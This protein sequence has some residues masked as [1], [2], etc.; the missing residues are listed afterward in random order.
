MFIVMTWFYVGIGA[1]VLTVETTDADKLRKN[2]VT[3]YSIIDS[4][5]FAIETK[6]NKG[7]IKVKQVSRSL[8]K[9]R[10]TWVQTLA[11]LKGFVYSLSSS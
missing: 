2:I 6:N 4:S 8:I 7:V 11:Y 10:R 1:P 3:S 9:I 5:H